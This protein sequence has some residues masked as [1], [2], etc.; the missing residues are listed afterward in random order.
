MS[1]HLHAGS[2]PLRLS[3]RGK[4]GQKH[5]IEI[6]DRQIARIVQ[7]CHDLPGYELF[8]YMNGD[9]KPAR[10]AS[11]DVNEYLREITQQDFT[12][13]DFRTWSGSALAVLALEKIGPAE[14][15]S[16]VKKNIAMAIKAVS[17]KL[18]NRPSA[19]RKY[20]VHPAVLEAYQE[21]T[22]FQVLSR[23]RNAERDTLHPEEFVLMSLLALWEEKTLSPS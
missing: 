7:R 18:G 10:I 17:Q 14:K 1:R 15:K 2:K 9:G 16:V 8:Q 6:E 5:Q 22:L 21:G 12:A 19:C 4:S 3:F 13:K 23:D 20:Y 11:E